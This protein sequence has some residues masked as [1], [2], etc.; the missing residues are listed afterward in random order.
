MWGMHAS[1]IEVSET[2]S[3][4]CPG[5]SFLKKVSSQRPDF[6]SRVEYLAAKVAKLRLDVTAA[7]QRAAGQ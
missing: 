4:E 5:D 2:P 1:T 7:K 3:S 6:R